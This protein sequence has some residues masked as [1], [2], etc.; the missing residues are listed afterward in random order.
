VGQR[1]YPAI[2]FKDGM[3]YREESKDMAARIRRW[4]LL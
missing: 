3:V 1:Q 4:E 2:D